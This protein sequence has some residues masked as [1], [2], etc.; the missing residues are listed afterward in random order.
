MPR[1]RGAIAN[2]CFFAIELS[3]GPSERCARNCNRLSGSKSRDQKG[4]DRKDALKNHWVSPG[5]I[6]RLNKAWELSL[7]FY[8]FFAH[9]R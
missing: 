3:P 9:G 1:P 7:G 2:A 4:L 8:F 6:V 5:S